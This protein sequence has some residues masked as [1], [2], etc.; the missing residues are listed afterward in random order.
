MGGNCFSKASANSLASG[1]EIVVYQTS[2]LS[3]F[4]RAIS[5]RFPTWAC[6]KEPN[7][8]NIRTASRQS[9][10]F[11]STP[12]D[13]KTVQQRFDVKIEQIDDEAQV[14]TPSAVPAEFSRQS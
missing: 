6:A 3:F 9:L 7:P 11:I 14:K 8:K 10:I 1:T 2:A 12:T 4:A 5:S 13:R